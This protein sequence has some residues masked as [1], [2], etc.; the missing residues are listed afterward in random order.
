[1]GERGQGERLALGAPHAAAD[2]CGP[3]RLKSNGLIA[4]GVRLIVSS[5][6]V[7]LLSRSIALALTAAITLTAAPAAADPIED[8]YKGK[9]LTIVSSAGVGAPLDLASRTPA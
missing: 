2:L 1:M 9:T 8:F 6:G 7:K 3:V 5:A 4:V